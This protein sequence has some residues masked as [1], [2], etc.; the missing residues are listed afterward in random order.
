MYTT[1]FYQR[2]GYNLDLLLTLVRLLISNVKF[3]P[4]NI[5]IVIY[6]Y[7]VMFDSFTGIKLFLKVIYISVFEAINLV[8]CGMSISMLY[9]CNDYYCVSLLP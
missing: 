2:I 6:F 1:Q 4:T 7:G 3:I 9:F 5:L 8:F